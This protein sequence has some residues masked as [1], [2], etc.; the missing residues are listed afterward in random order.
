MI[1]VKQFYF[2]DLRECCYVLSD[3]TRECVIVDP[4]LST[5]RER[6]RLKQYI[7]EN[8]LKPVKLLCTHG[9]FDHT[10]GNRFVT[11]TYGIRTYIH[12]EDRDLLKVAKATSRLFDIHIDDPSLDTVDI[13]D[14]D[15]VTFGNSSL[16]VISTPGHTWGS[17]I[18]YNEAEK[19]CLTGD[20]LFAGNCGRTDL[21]EGDSK[22]MCSSLVDKVARMI[23][24]DATIYPGHGPESTMLEELA[25]NPYLRKGTWLRFNMEDF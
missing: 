22:A 13:K 3:E 2:N 17:V 4:G 21:P 24:H 1:T 15:K 7:S 14:G 16:D 20:T 10:M 12:P 5:E 19:I 6:E 9:H 18:F 11:D 23:R 25:H 8:G